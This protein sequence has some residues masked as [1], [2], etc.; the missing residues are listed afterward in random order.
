MLFSFCFGIFDKTR[1]MDIIKKSVKD[2]INL[3]EG[4]PYKRLMNHKVAQGF[5][6]DYTIPMENGLF[7]DFSISII[8][9]KSKW[10]IEYTNRITG[11]TP[12]KQKIL[13]HVFNNDGHYKS[14]FIVST[15]KK[16]Y[17]NVL[18]DLMFF[19]KSIIENYKDFF[20]ISE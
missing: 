4:L 1:K 17:K 2:H 9:I 14:N 18:K 19:Q 10:Y 8:K 6:V 7:W 20:G 15:Y 13:E 3:F 16:D 5:V 11:E 12:D